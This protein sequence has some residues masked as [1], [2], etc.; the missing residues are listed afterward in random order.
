MLDKQTV[1]LTSHIDSR[2]ADV[3]QRLDQVEKNMS[4]QG[5]DIAEI[6][7]Q[8][9]SQASQISALTSRLDGLEKS[10]T[11]SVSA[12]PDKRFNDERDCEAFLGGFENSDSNIIHQKAAAIIGQ[13]A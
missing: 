4:K 2:F 9:T 5:D 12:P 8:Q 11:R 13:P 1:S 6:T 7:L 3:S 10:G